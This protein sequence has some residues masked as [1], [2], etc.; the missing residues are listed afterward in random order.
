[1]LTRR[2]IFLHPIVHK[3]R[4]NVFSGDSAPQFSCEGNNLCLELTMERI[5]I[6]ALVAMIMNLPF[7]HT[8][9]ECDPDVPSRMIPRPSA[10]PNRSISSLPTGQCEAGQY[11][12]ERNACL[13]CP[14]GT[15]LT[16]RMA[17]GQAAI[18]CLQCYVPRDAEIIVE[19]CTS[20][21]DTTVQCQS[22]YYRSDHSP[23]CPCSAGRCEPCDVCGLG[24]NLYRDHEVVSCSQFQNAKCCEEENSDTNCSPKTTRLPIKTSQFLSFK[25]TNSTVVNFIPS[26]I[27]QIQATTDQYGE[28][29]KPPM[30]LH[31]TDVI[32]QG[33]PSKLSMLLH[34]TDVIT[35]GEPSKPPML[36]HCTDVITQGEPS[37]PPMLLHCT[38]VILHRVSLANYHVTPL[39]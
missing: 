27:L 31:C 34:C 10:Q 36:L 1:M 21:K 9:C 16:K 32:T 6:L 18:V 14:A 15:F 12:G 4:Q 5:I 26:D 22:K 28:P 8:K 23:S 11:L 25:L 39:P 35:Q 7:I 13:P 19:N 37:K 20:T 33:E 29:S 17:S 24:I 38:D 2:Q 30:L 3:S